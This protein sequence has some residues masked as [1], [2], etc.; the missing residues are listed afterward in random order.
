[1]GKYQ[2]GI[3]LAAGIDLEFI[4]YIINDANMQWKNYGILKV[5]INISNMVLF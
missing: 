1:M 4:D 3:K 2:N 5:T